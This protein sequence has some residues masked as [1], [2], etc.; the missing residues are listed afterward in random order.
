MLPGKYVPSAIGAL[1][2]CS[3][4]AA[5]VFFASCAPAACLSAGGDYQL[6]SLTVGAGGGA[7]AAGGDYLSRGLAGQPILPPNLGARTGAEYSDRAG[8]YNPPHFTYQRALATSLTL[9]GGNAILNLPAGAVNKEAYDIILNKDVLSAPL[10][11][12]PG[13][14]AAANSRVV[15]NEGEWSTPLAANMAETHVFDE[16][17]AWRDDFSSGGTL[18][19]DYRDDND[20]GVIDGTNPPVRTET[21][22]IWSLDRAR[23]VWVKVPAMTVDRATRRIIVPLMAPGVYAILGTLDES[24]KNVYAYPVPFRPNGRGAGV[25]SGL[26]GTA[27]DGITFA[28]LPQ[29]GSIEIYTLD[30]LLVKKLG[31]PANLNPALMKWDVKNSAGEKVR[32]DVYIWRVVSGPN[33]KTGKL[34]VI[35]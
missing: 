26:T 7:P 2:S 33:V 32:S 31:I 10:L 30:G 14:V 8:F 4:L 34:M 11:S 20:D 12:D 21:A 3:L 35:W 17:S 23:D 13:E 18:S 19:M 16:Q 6:D 25:G 22:M 29:Q 24:V 5:V 28:N 1:N 27:G 9:P 15:R